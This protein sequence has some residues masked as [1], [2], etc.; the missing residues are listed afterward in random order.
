MGNTLSAGRK[1]APSTGNPQ[2]NPTSG[3]LS[4]HHPQA[5][6]PLARKLGLGL[7]RRAT[8]AGALAGGLTGLVGAVAPGAV[9]T[10]SLTGGI[11]LATFPDGVPTLPPF[12]GAI[13]ASTLVTVLVSLAGRRRTDVAALNARVPSLSDARDHG[14]RRHP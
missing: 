10:G 4:A 11:A 9:R 5:P 3:R 8:P 7:W 1:Q 13:L 14:H 2:V 6:Q 12:A